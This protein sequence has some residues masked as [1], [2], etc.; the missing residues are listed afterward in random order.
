ML[1]QRRWLGF[2]AFVLLMVLLC[3]VL[4]RWQWGRYQ[5]RQQQNAALDAALAA[6]AVPVEDLLDA[7]PADPGT[8]R[9]PEGLTWRAVTATG[10][11]D[12]SGERAVR[13]RPQDGRNGFWIVTPLRTSDGVLLVNRG[14]LPVGDDPTRTPPAPPPPAGEVSIVGRLRAGEATDRSGE[15]PVGQAWAADP[16]MLVAPAAA[17]RYPAY[18]QLISSQPTGEQGLAELPVP[19]HRGTNNLVYT[20]QWLVFAVV[21]IIGWLMLIR[22]EAADARTRDRVGAQFDHEGKPRGGQPQLP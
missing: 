17:D 4:A 21:G 22:R 5:L 9:L 6:P 3:V 15:L 2:T 12:T 14:W 20:V 8:P 18:V 16:Q 1:R 13:R 10:V 7:K 11:F 19:G